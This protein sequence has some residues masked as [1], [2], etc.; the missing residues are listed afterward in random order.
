MLFSVILL[1]FSSFLL[2]P[3]P[4]VSLTTLST[5]NSSIYPSSRVLDAAVGVGVTYDGFIAQRLYIESRRLPLRVRV[6]K[7]IY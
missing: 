5:A 3:S 2:L 4:S 1:Y 7:A 6:A